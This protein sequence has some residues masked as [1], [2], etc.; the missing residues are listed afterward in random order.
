MPSPAGSSTAAA[1]S[2]RSRASSYSATSRRDE[3]GTPS[4]AD[5]LAADDGNPATVAQI[6][7][8]DAGLRRLVEETYRARGGKGDGLPGA[9]GVSGRGRVDFRF[10]IDS[11]GRALHPHEERRD[12]QEGRG[13]EGD[14]THR[15]DAGGPG[16]RTSQDVKSPQAATATNPVAS[17]PESIAAG[18]RRT[19]PTA[20]PAMATWRRVR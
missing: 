9:A 16:L 19:T 8:M 1:G 13:C 7:E 3:S 11:D 17:T 15:R 10:A 14:V 6:H 2:R 20:P 4:L 12:D 18:K 5:V